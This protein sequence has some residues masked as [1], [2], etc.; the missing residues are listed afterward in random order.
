MTTV[1][2][3]YMYTDEDMDLIFQY[4]TSKRTNK[5][6]ILKLLYQGKR[7]EATHGTV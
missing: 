7:K 6:K 5:I 4:L 2:T 1:K 3:Y